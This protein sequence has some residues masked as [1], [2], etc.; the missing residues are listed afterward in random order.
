MVLVVVVDHTIRRIRP[1]RIVNHRVAG[2]FEGPAPPRIHQ[3]EG[4]APLPAPLERHHSSGVRP[5]AAPPRPLAPPPPRGRP[6]PGRAPGSRSS[7]LRSWL[8]SNS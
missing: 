3:R 6:P 4:G 1:D 7:S 8:S 2:G 5:P